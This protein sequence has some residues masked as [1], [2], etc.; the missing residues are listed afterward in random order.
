M[1][2]LL[3]VW[4]I[5]VVDAAPKDSDMHYIVRAPYMA[6]VF[7]SCHQTN[8]EKTRQQG[9]ANWMRPPCGPWRR[10]FVLYN[11]RMACFFSIGHGDAKTI[12]SPQLGFHSGR[13]QT[14]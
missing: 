9:N 1:A 5:I 8:R 2:D 14:T 7:S 11:S 3:R 4:A 10:E 13:L 12:Q 6:S